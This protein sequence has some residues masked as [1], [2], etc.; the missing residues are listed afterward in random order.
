MILIII[1]FSMSI[2]NNINHIKELKIQAEN[3]K[4][5]LYQTNQV[6]IKLQKELEKSNHHPVNKTIWQR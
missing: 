3:M 1:Y 4:E 5:N 6:I 2:K